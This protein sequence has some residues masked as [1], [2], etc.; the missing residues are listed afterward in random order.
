MCGIA[1]I[2]MYQ[3][4]RTQKQLDWIKDL[5]SELAVENQ[6][7]GTHA[8]G[9]AVFGEDNYEVLKHNVSAD[10]FTQYDTY[11]EF[12]DRNINNK[13]HNILIHT[14]YATQGSPSVNENN[15]PIESATS[16]GIHNGMIYND[17][18]LFHSENLFR[19]A[20]VD[21]EVIFR[22][23]DK[24]MKNERENT[25]TVAEKLSGVYAVA[26]VRKEERNILNYF[27]NSNPTTFAYI[28]EL[29]IT[30][31]ASQ[32]AF[33]RTGINTTNITSHHSNQYVIRTDNIQYFHPKEDIIMQFD[34]TENT[35]IQQLEQTPLKFE[36]NLNGWYGNYYG[37]QYGYQ[38]YDDGWYDE[39]RFDRTG[40]M[41]S[42]KSNDKND[43]KE[44]YENIYDFIIKRN[45]EHLMSDDDYAKMMELLDQ[46]EKNEWSSGYKAGR[47]ST[48]NDMKLLK[49][50]KLLLEFQMEENKAN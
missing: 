35:P 27:R 24:E 6:V 37:S 25:K 21:S 48:E 7:R 12:M 13:T 38:N 22:L 45:L 11:L 2:M 9:I 20:E 30:V 43:G 41:S 3:K 34:V 5:A 14:R 42:T 4:N 32:E 36:E 47:E 46:N 33:I 18:E 8:T 16:I 39:F 29:N 23:V 49:E 31:F 40:K 15:H 28:P 19:L 17:G 1:G 50:E 26:F 10:E 44:D